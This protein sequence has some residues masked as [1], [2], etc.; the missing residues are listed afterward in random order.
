M[1]EMSIS[2]VT[3]PKRTNIRHN[4]RSFTEDEWKSPAHQHIDRS[5]S[6]LNI[7]IKQVNIQD[8]YNEEFGPSLVAYNAKQKRSDRI[9]KDYLKHVKKSKTLDV[10]REFV[11]AIGSKEDWDNYSDNDKQIVGNLLAKYV[12]DFEERHKQL[13]VYN[14]VVHLDEAGAPHLHFNI[15]PI[16]NGYKNGL[17]K[18][19]SFSKALL[20]EGYTE[21]GRGQ[22]IQ[23][24]EQEIK[25]LE[26][27]MKKLNIQRKIVGTN[28]IEDM[29]EYKQLIQEVEKERAKFNKE[30]KAKE[31]HSNQLENFIE[32]LEQKA[33]YLTQQNKMLE[34]R[35]ELIKHEMDKLN[36]KDQLKKQFVEN[37]VDKALDLAQELTEKR[38]KSLKD[39]VNIAESRRLETENKYREV[40]SVNKKWASKYQM[41]E[42]ENKSLKQENKFLRRVIG[43]FQRAFDRAEEFF[44]SIG[45]WKTFKNI[46]RQRDLEEYK[47]FQD[48]R[49]DPNL[50]G[51]SSLKKRIDKHIDNDLWR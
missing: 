19:P 50:E 13:I 33:E 30:I 10:Q 51:Q 25:K 16:A 7:Y 20:Q 36:L 12:K 11:V 40:L 17:D 6:S 15:V 5:K 14:A 34:E 31:K 48:I 8:I 18:Q 42:N 3:N 35:N 26:Q 1:V 49:H 9:I 22:F 23:F 37:T 46:F 44:K 29:R 47:L 39:R 45:F 43:K 2:F 4:N 24:R 38:T 41:L 21:R 28:K 27:L 32:D